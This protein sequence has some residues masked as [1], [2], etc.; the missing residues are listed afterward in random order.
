MNEMFLY[1]KNRCEKLEKASR[2]FF[3][4][5]TVY[6]AHLDNPEES[7]TDFHKIEKLGV[8]LENSKERLYLTIIGQ[9]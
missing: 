9:A 5:D 1:Y 6:N 2:W 3:A 4:Y 7:E 8:K